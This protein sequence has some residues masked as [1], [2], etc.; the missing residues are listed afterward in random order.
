MKTKI[1]FYRLL[2]RL[3]LCTALTL[4]VARSATAAPATFTTQTYP[5]LGNNHVAADFNG[6]GK[7]DL[8]G[9]G[10]NSAGV[11]LGNGDGTFRAKIDYAVGGQAQDIAAGDFNGD[12]KIDLAV[13]I[14]TLQIGLSLLTGTGTGAFNAP[15]N[16]ANTTGFD[17]PAIVATDLN[18]DGKLDLVIAHTIA[19]YTAPC[20]VTRLLT[21]MLGNGDGSFQPARNIDVGTGMSRIV[22][23]D[24]NRDG[25]KDLAIA[26]DQAQVYI[27]LGVGD[28]TFVQQPTITLIGGSTLGVDATDISV[29]DLNRD[30]F[31][32][33]VVS[34]GLNGSRTAILLG[35][36]NGTFRVPSILS[37]PNRRVPQYNAVADFNG[38]GIPDIAL[39][40]ADGTGGLF[41][42]LNGNGDGTFQPPVYYAVPPAG[43]SIAG[44]RITAA[45]LNGDG[46][47]DIALE[48]TGASPA[49]KVL[50]NSTGVAPAP[51]TV[52]T[53]S[54]SPATVTGGNSATGTLTLSAAV[55]TATVVAV[56]SNNAAA[57]VPTSVTVPAGASSAS[58]TITTAQVSI[59]TSAIIT[60]TLNGVARSA[61]L[62]IN[63]LTA[64]SDTVAITR[65]EYDSAKQ[66]LRAE[67]T[68]TR[69]D[70]TLQCYV[71]ATAQLIGT[72]TNNG[73]GK[74]SGQFGWSVNPANITVRSSFGGQATGAVT[75]K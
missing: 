4:I 44:G 27:L 75:L 52:S 7:L 17:S 32:D 39:S 12:A 40:L 58:F 54:L 64:G 34:I 70:A 6:D 9:S 15:I 1:N 49:F 45:D 62:T 67:A 5:F 42:I 68:S 21:V 71:T 60:A 69:A 33:L 47:P 13:T 65:A 38:D 46:K 20:T 22:V 14:N 63:P 3:L 61:S 16:L 56:S 28:G 23:G 50:I 59:A 53:L 36:G 26:G 19:C 73:G 8:A 57:T 51:V 29:A 48:V 11:M 55:Q 72:L 43:S 35:N 31:Q 10:A 18:N 2:P 37:E 24:F 30:G 66:V 25:I 74:Y 41:E